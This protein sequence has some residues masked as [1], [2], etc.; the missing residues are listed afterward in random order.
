MLLQARDHGAPPRVYFCD[1]DCRVKYERISK[2]CW[3][4][5]TLRATPSALASQRT[6]HGRGL[7][8]CGHEVLVEAPG[9][10]LCPCGFT[11]QATLLPRCM[12][13]DKPLPV[14]GRRCGGKPVVTVGL[15]MLSG[16]P[17]FWG[18]D[19]EM[20]RPLARAVL[21][22][23]LPPPARSEALARILA[24][25][26]FAQLD[27]ACAWRLTHE[28]VE[29]LAIT[30]GPVTA[31]RLRRACRGYH[32]DFTS[33]LWR[34]A[35][36]LRHWKQIGITASEREDRRL[37]AEQDPRPA[38][39]VLRE[40]EQDPEFVAWAEAEAARDEVARG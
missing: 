23:L 18:C 27:Q 34:A 16:G 2:Y 26:I 17:F 12:A 24:E 3:Y 28:S 14:V 39:A 5:F 10:Q 9:P 37:L 35:L 32:R 36:R 33:R 40:L 15:D 20:T 22:H 4:E 13:C 38:E 11:F 1:E 30:P 31:G 19:E 7:A 25:M 21:Q 8:P 6:N 29:L